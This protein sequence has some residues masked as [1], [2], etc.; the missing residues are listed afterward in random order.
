[1]QELDPDQTDGMW[2]RGT[3]LRCA[4]Q[5]IPETLFQQR[6]LDHLT[7]GVAFVDRRLQ[8]VLWNRAAERLTGMSSESVFQ[9]PWLPSLLE[10]RSADG[11]EIADV[12]CPVRRA[13]AGRTRSHLRLSVR[14]RGGGRMMVD[15]HVVAVLGPDGT[16]H[17]ATCRAA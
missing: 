15:V 11:L 7:D 14:S 6:L 12:D 17:G 10:M 5:I 2:Q 9:R 3:T 13:I 1:L 8:I 16:T 4:G